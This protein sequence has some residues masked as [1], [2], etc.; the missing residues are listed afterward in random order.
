M[1]LTDTQLAA[2]LRQTDE[3]WVESKVDSTSTPNID[4]VLDAVEGL[5]VEVRSLRARIAAAD[6]LHRAFDILDVDD[7]CEDCNNSLHGF[8]GECGEWLCPNKYVVTACCTC[9]DADGDLQTW[10]CPTHTA[11]HPEE[12]TPDA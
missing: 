7:D 8:E 3:A 1:E 10:P 2:L 6:Y 4:A 5:V 9:S 12:E 11:L